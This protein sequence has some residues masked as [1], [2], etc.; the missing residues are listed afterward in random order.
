[1]RIWI[2]FWNILWKDIRTYYLK[3]PN[4]SW[5]LIFPLAWTTMFFIKSGGDR[6]Q[7]PGYPARGGVFVRAFRHHIHAGRHR[8]L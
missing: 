2:A 7:H 5:G 3:P 6:F 4:I 1:M 8:D